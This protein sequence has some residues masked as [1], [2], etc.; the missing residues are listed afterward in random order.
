MQATSTVD[1]VPALQLVCPQCGGL[2]ADARPTVTLCDGCGTRYPAREC[3]GPDLRPQLAV[4]RLI[5]QSIEPADV[6][7]GWAD[8]IVSE[9]RCGN[10][11]SLHD[12]QGPEYRYGNSLNDALVSRLEL[13]AGYRLLD[14]GCGVENQMSGPTKRLEV[15]H[16]GIDYSGDLPDY[17]GDVHCLPFADD[18]FDGALSIAVLEHVRYPYLAAQEAAG[19]LRPGGI[20]AGSVAFLE[21]FHMD[22]VFHHTA[23]GIWSV[24][25]EAGFTSIEIEPNPVWDVAR[26]AAEMGFLPGVG[27]RIKYWSGLEVRQRPTSVASSWR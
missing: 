14:V 26:A 27:W 16:V 3:R 13:R 22:S 10:G 15:D 24:L 5:R 2:L 9:M 1:G 25:H 4:H 8:C 21:P 19:V 18:S 11:P 17:L 23:R 7:E 20:F 6:A 12:L